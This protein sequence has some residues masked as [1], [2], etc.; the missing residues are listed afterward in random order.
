MVIFPVHAIGV[1][2]T[3]VS[4]T[5]LPKN[6]YF[7]HANCRRPLET[8]ASLGI[9]LHDCYVNGIQSHTFSSQDIL[10]VLISHCLCIIK[11]SGDLCGTGRFGEISIRNKPRLAFWLCEYL[12]GNLL[13]VTEVFVRSCKP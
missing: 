6:V 9:T 7:Y 3:A 10:L 12:I 11:V 13:N 8:R 2:L 5:E 1:K 4:E